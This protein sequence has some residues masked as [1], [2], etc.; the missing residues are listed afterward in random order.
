M[1]R[2]RHPEIGVHF[3]S[4]QTQR[5]DMK[6][7]SSEEPEVASLG[8]SSG[9]VRCL[10]ASGVFVITTMLAIV[11]NQKHVHNE[12]TSWPMTNS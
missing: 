3:H 6:S 1:V 2:Q 10:V 5:S 4:L 11:C 9:D 7:A 12:S 8:G